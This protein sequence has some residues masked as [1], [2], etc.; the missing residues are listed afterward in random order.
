[1]K[2]RILSFLN[3]EK[4]TPARFADIIG[5]QPATISH[6]IAERNKP[7]LEFI[8]K[9]LI[10]FPNLRPEWLITGEGNMYK[11]QNSQNEGSTTNLFDNKDT[12]QVEVA[13]I[14]IENTVSNIL[15][16]ENNQQQPNIEQN[17]NQAIKPESK[18]IERIIICYSD[19]TFEFYY[20]R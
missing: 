7:S 14:N 20:P 5:V 16:N 17:N 15:Q 2:N 1:M 10:S 11:S 8:Q 12:K 19:K 13:D 6:I 3:I 18:E 4:L 9:M